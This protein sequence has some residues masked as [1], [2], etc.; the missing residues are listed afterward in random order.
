MWN[1]DVDEA[2]E[3]QNTPRLIKALKDDP[4][5]LKPG[6]A[7]AESILHRAAFRGMDEA[8]RVIVSMGYDVNRD[9]RNESPLHYAVEG[10]KWTS[11]EVLFELGADIDW[12]SG[13]VATPL[14]TAVMERN[15]EMASQ[16]ILAGA[17][18]NASFVNHNGKSRRPLD[19]AELGNDRKMVELLQ[20]HGS[21]VGEPGEFP[22]TI[23]EDCRLARMYRYISRHALNSVKTFVLEYPDLLDEDKGVLQYAF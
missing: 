23:E 12:G 22:T 17:D 11:V 16:L 5:V 21:I 2:L 15:H 4:D 3:E 18:V 7:L 8:I 13:R 20:S 1:K 10:G 9:Y 6:L 14:V 19:L